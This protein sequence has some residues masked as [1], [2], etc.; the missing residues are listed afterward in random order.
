MNVLTN[1]SKEDY[2]LF[3]PVLVL[4]MDKYSYQL[5]NSDE[6]E[7]HCVKRLT[8]ILVIYY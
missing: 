3:K 4:S 7:E 5:Y 8:S 2:R 6:K 1:R